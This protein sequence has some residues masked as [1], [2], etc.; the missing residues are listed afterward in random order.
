M[1]EAGHGGRII[2]MPGG[3]AVRPLY[4]ESLHCATKGG[5]LAATWTWALELESY[6]ITVNAARGGVRTPGTEALIARIRHQLGENGATERI[7]DRELG[8]FD[9]EEA[10]PLVVWLASDNAS[11]VTGQFVG[12]DG[13]KITIWDL[14]AIGAEVHREDGWDE[15]AIESIVRPL[16]EKATERARLRLR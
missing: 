2:D 14:P 11:G 9:S 3:A 13:P 10:A 15:D 16:L 8:F 7:S 4:A 6:G 5:L 12:I 1:I